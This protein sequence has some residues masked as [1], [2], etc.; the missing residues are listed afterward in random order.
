[1]WTREF[2]TE[3]V[4]PQFLSGTTGAK[5]IKSINAWVQLDNTPPINTF[6]SSHKHTLKCPV[7]LL[8]F[9]LLLALFYFLCFSDGHVWKCCLPW[10]SLQF[11]IDFTHTFKCSGCCI[12]LFH[13]FPA[14]IPLTRVMTHSKGNFGGGVSSYRSYEGR[15]YFFVEG[16]TLQGL[17]GKFIFFESP[18]LWWGCVVCVCVWGGVAVISRGRRSFRGWV[19]GF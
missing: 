14:T 7:L 2:K 1:M 3:H 17:E 16:G 6:C 8:L 18:K 12:F 9:I 11:F 19:T 13:P 5:R 4:S 15:H 10:Y